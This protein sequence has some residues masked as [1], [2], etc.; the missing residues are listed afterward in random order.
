M[1]EGVLVAALTAGETAAVGGAALL[2]VA[3]VLFGV[4]R[5]VRR[6]GRA[7]EERMA[8]LVAELD[9]RTREMRDELVDTLRR[10]QEQNRRVRAYSELATSID[11]DEVLHRTLDAARAIP[12]VEAAHVAVATATGETV[13][14]STGLSDAEVEDIGLGTGPAGRRVRAI[15]VDFSPFGSAEES[16]V[17]TGLALPLRSGDASLGLLTLYSRTPGHAFTATAVQMAEDLAIRA[18]PAIENASRY[19]EARRLAD[20]DAHT[21]L[22]NRRYFHET[23]GREVARSQRYERPLALIVF[24]LDDFKEINDRLGHLAGDAVLGQVGERIR[25]VVRSADVACRVGGDEFGIILPES[26]LEDAE[27]LCERLKGQMTLQ[28]IPQAGRL[29]ISA[30]VAG[31]RAQD[32]AVTLF[33]RADDALYRAKEAGKGRVAIAPTVIGR[34]ASD[35]SPSSA[36]SRIESEEG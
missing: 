7:A 27:Q 14:R 13:V 9:R 6:S 1:S 21:G 12:D 2:A 15:T 8:A 35:A 29:Q 26:T 11:L 31:L 19:H 30:G 18:A 25:S 3:L 32:D 33:E 5:A 10:E 20:V 4:V 34:S 16:P 17:L 28:P 22:H 23:L 36:I 24:D